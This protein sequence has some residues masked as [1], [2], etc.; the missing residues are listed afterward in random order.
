MA[1]REKVAVSVTVSVPL[2]EALSDLVGTGVVSVCFVLDSLSVDDAL[3]DTV[4]DG[5]SWGVE[6]GDTVDEPS[7]ESERES[8][9]VGGG[10]IVLVGVLSKENVDVTLPLGV[11]VAPLAVADSPALAV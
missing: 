10:V 5:V 9:V 4:H 7:N 11:G 3:S 2:A 6:V 1:L 8:D